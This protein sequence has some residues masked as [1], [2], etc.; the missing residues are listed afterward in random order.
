VD[1]LY[2]LGRSYAEVRANRQAVPVLLQVLRLKADHVEAYGTLGSVYYSLE[3]WAHAA[4]ALTQFIQF[5]PE[6]AFP[7]FVL[8]TCFDKLGRAKEAI[9]HYN[10]YLEYDDGSSDVR[11]FQARQRAKTL[12]RRLK[13]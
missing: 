1:L 7:H 10:K 2:L 3:D 13:N 8:A 9:L 12:E 5:N 4:Q 6:Q 11:S